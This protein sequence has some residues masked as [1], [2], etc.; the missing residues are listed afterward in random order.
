MELPLKSYLIPMCK[1]AN[2]MWYA[3]G[4][5]KYWAGTAMALKDR[6]ISCLSPEG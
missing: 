6:K 4:A 1:V 3:M 2:G 5:R